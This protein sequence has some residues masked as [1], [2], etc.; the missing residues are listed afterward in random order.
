MLDE[1]IVLWPHG[2]LLNIAQFVPW[3]KWVVIGIS[4]ISAG[5]TALA[6]VLVWFRQEGLR[7]ILS[8]AGAYLL[9]NVICHQFIHAFYVARPFV[10]YHFTPLYPHAASTSFP[11]TL[12]AFF[13]CVAIA[14]WRAWR[15]LGWVLIACTIEVALA[16]VY[17]GVHL[18]IDVVAGALIGGGAGLFMWLVLGLPAI[19]RGV[20]VFDGL[21]SK[22]G[23]RP[24]LE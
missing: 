19:A 5:L 9:I 13:A 18:A 2:G 10:E 8:I 15:E 7:C 6:I 16:C 12:T 23:L 22:V 11:S 14:V 1:M 24:S 4:F 3:L 20:A 21:L 17:V